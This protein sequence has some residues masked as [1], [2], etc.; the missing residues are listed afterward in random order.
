LSGWPRPS[1]IKVSRP[2]LSVRPEVK[3]YAFDIL[4][5]GDDDLRKLPLHLRKASLERLVAHRPTRRFLG[6]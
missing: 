1:L 5:E 6:T 4:V 2:T 3:L